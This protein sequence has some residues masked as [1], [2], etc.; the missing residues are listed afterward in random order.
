MNKLKVLFVS[1]YPPRQCGIGTFTRDLTQAL[2]QEISWLTVNIAAID[3]NDDDSYDYPPEVDY[4]VNNCRPESYAELAQ[5]VNG[6]DYDIACVQHEFGIFSG[7]WG[8]DLADFYQQCEKPIMTT[9]HTILPNCPDLP[10]QITRIV[11]GNSFVTVVM[12]RIGTELLRNNCGIFFGNIKVIPHGVPPLRLE[13]EFRAKQELDLRDREVISTFGLISRGKGIEYVIAAM[14]EIVRHRPNAIYCILGRTHPQV[15]RQEGEKY[16]E[17]LWAM[18][19]QLKVQDHVRFVNRFLSDEELARYLEATDVYITPYIG[20]DQITSGAM[21]RAVYY[22]KAI[23]ST[24]YLYATELLGNG[25]GRLVPFKDSAAIAQEITA[26]LSDSGLKAGMEAGIRH[27]GRTMSWP[28]VARQ[29]ARELRK[30]GQA[31]KILAPA[32]GR[33]RTRHAVTQKV[34]QVT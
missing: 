32:I 29:Y 24:P 15:V 10:R 21:A 3:C 34:M 6:S 5:F 26:V 16:R 31:V 1:T 20:A 12:A 17:E 28:S 14:P 9:L 11:V 33:T 22:G 19:E 2:R 27:Y 23:V 4:R 25:R 18:V 30:I 7:E 13:G 8:R